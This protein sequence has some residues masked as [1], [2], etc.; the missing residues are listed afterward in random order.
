[1]G[2]AFEYAVIPAIVALGI[3]LGRKAAIYPKRHDS[4]RVVA[5]IWG[6]ICGPPGCL[7]SPPM[8]EALR[9]LRRL[10]AEAENAH[11]EAMREFRIALGL[12]QAR[13]E[14]AKAALKAAAKDKET[15]ATTLEERA[16][17]A[18]TIEMPAEPTPRRYSTSDTSME[19][20]GALLAVNPNIGIVRDELTGWLRTLERPENGTARSF[21]LE[22]YEGLGGSFQFDRIARGHI[23]VP[24]L[25]VSVLGSIQPGPLRAFL[26]GVARGEEADDG[27]IARFGLLVWPDTGGLWKNV[28]RWPDTSAK[29]RAFEIFSKLDSLDPVQAGATPDT[30]GGPAGFRFEG[31]AQDLFDSWR[32]TLENKKL[33]QPDENPLVDSHLAKYRKL[34]PA[35]SLLFHVAQ[36]V[37]RGQPGPVSLASAELAVKWCEL[38]EAHARRVYACVADPDIESARVLSEKIK[39]GALA[40]PFAFAD[41]YHRGWSGLDDAPSC[42]RA[43][44]ILEDLGWLRVV[45]STQT[46]GAPK[47]EIYI[48]PKLPRRTVE[49]KNM[50]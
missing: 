28:D 49:N 42:R 8:R 22:G 33:H 35:L 36:V 16:R 2:C 15:S 1:V 18:A 17:E 39:A 45:R 31:L 5:N 11:G 47:E 25:M 50:R 9:P 3:V 12:A 24:S 30:D 38:L 40:S 6:A 32:D 48:H 4:W 10:E 43:V 21:Y 26:R 27:L 46:G 23:V 41:V 37:D 14:A 13:A 29:N 34:M 20:L 44:G 7:K 19:A